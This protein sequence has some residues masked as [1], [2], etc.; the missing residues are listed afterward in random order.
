MLRS[1]PSRTHIDSDW[2]DPRVVLR[3]PTFHDRVCSCGNVRDV[4]L[5]PTA[6]GTSCS[7]SIIH[8]AHDSS[9]GAIHA[10]SL[11]APAQFPVRSGTDGPT[12]L[13][14]RAPLLQSQQLLASVA[15][16]V[17]LAGGLDQILQVG[18]RQ[19][20]AQVDEFAVV[21]VFDVDGAPAVGAAAHLLSVDVDVVLG[22][23]DGEGD[24][25]LV[26]GC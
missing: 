26:I 22:A 19:E 8:S 23:D 17:D 5:V 6:R 3:S 7:C 20:V 24:D 12:A 14:S 21:L 18:A 25:A 1:S 11:A 15:L 2:R 13:A 4:S 9:I 10:G 16:V